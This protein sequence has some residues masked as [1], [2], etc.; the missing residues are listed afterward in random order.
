MLKPVLCCQKPIDTYAKI[1][2]K[3]EGIRKNNIY[4]LSSS[5]LAADVDICYSPIPLRVTRITIF[6][7][8]ISKGLPI[9]QYNIH[10]QYDRTSTYIRKDVR[11]S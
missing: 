7:N 5:P 4:W 6:S 1:I 3:S 9:L 8:I 10:V 2:V 11:I